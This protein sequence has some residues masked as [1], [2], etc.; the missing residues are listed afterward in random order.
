MKSIDVY[1]TFDG[2]CREAMK[3]YAEA[4]DAPVEM[5]TGGDMPGAAE[6]DRERILH[7]RIAKGSV[8]LMAS[9]TMSMT[10]FQVKQGNNFSVSIDYAGPEEQDHIFAKL[11]AGGTVTM[12][13]QDTFWGA[14]FGML[15][16]QFGIQWMFNLDK[17]KV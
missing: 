5:M 12:P 1:L 9:D 11:Q 3:F 4:L 13:L 2:N 16:D 15:T 17:L 14:R 6:S 10:P 8:R 7:A